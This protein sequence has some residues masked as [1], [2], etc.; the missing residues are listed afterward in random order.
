MGT[1]AIIVADSAITVVGPALSMGIS[2]TGN[3]INSTIS[4]K[5]TTTGTSTGE[6]WGG[7]SSTTSGKSYTTNKG[8]SK[9]NTEGKSENYTDT[10]GSSTGMSEN[11]QLTIENK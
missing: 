8:T 11:L 1:N 6:S 9:T 2:T 5:T 7:S 3:M 4:P 10:K